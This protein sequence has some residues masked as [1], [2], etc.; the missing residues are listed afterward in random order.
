MEERK[1]AHTQIHACRVFFAEFLHSDLF[2]EEEGV[3]SLITP[4]GARCERLYVVGAIESVE[5]RGNVVRIRLNDTTAS[6]PVFA[7]PERYP[8]ELDKKRAEAERYLAV[9][10]TVNAR[11]N[12]DG[13]KRALI[14][15]EA[16]GFVEERARAAWLLTTARR[17]IERIEQLR[18]FSNEP[19]AFMNVSSESVREHY[20]LDNVRLDA[21]ASTAINAVNGLLA[22]YRAQTQTLVVEQ[23]KKAGKSGLDRSRL[24]E[25]L[26]NGQGLPETWLEEVLVGLMLEGQCYELESHVLRSA[27]S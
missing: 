3:T 6:V 12:A 24:L 15:A 13:R 5:T 25:Q 9:V 2:M 11:T 17:T 4:T 7:P 10:G 8:A 20:A 16:L 21:L 22:H 14:L 23:I 26:R 27:R 19:S 1:R 18:I